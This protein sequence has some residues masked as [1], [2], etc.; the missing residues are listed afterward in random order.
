MSVQTLSPAQPYLFNRHIAAM[1]WPLQLRLSGQ[2]RR[3]LITLPPR[4][5]K[6]ICASV[7]FPAYAIGRNPSLRIICAGY[8]EFSVFMK[9]P[10]L[11]LSY[12]LPRRPIEPTSPC[13]A[14]SLR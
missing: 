7:A 8:S 12:A 2:I 3:L 5:L 10:A 9:L 11:P 14:S 4:S 6:S 13:A 1:A